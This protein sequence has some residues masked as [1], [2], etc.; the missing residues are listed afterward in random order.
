MKTFRI[1]LL[2][3]IIIGIALICSQK[4][5][6]P[7]L[8]NKILLWRGDSA[9]TVASA[10]TDYKNSTYTIEGQQVTLVNGYAAVPAAPGSASETITKY[11]GDESVGDLNGDGLPDIA[12]ILT[13]SNGGSGTF[14]YVVAALKT[15]NGYQGTNAVFLGD[16]IAPQTTEISAG[17]LAVNYADRRPSDPMTMTP[18]VGVT[19]HL[20]VQGTTLEEVPAAVVG[21]HCGGNITTAAICSAGYH[22]APVPGS[23]LPFGDVGGICVAN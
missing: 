19:K 7:R 18:S 23:H 9:V 17:E 5:W 4:L 10:F 22:C 1:F 8:V 16:R 3:L 2:V 13:Q 6:V 12:F 11:F 15:A 21:V 14:Y 20:R